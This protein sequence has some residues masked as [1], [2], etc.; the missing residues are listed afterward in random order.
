MIQSKVLSLHFWE[1]TNNCVDY[2]ANRTPTKA[3]KNITSEEAWS[4]IKP[5]V[6][7]FHVFSSEAWVDV[8]DEKMKVLQPKSGKC[9]FVGN[10]EDV[11]GSRLLQPNSNE[12][13]IKIYVEFDEN[14]ST[15]KLNSM[16]VPYLTCEPLF[17]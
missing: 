16:F 15:C 12:I 10:C 8:H 2:M 11:K 14:L 5:D 3:L 6:S 7:H 13:I 9:I 1:K 4:K 17:S